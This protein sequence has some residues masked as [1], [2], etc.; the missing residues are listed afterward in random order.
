MASSSLITD[1]A[2]SRERR[3]N[4]AAECGAFMRFLNP[5]VTLMH[6]LGQPQ[7]AIHPDI[8]GITLTMDP[9]ISLD[10]TPYQQWCNAHIYDSLTSLAVV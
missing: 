7:K 5:V 1:E 10:K 4:V 2:S 8:H 3:D 6:V 9:I